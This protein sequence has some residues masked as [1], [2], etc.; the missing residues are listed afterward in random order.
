LIFLDDDGGELEYKDIVSFKVLFGYKINNSTLPFNKIIYVDAVNG[1][2]DTGDGTENNPYASPTVAKDNVTQDKTAIY[3]VNTGTY[4]I[5]QGLQ[6]LLLT[7]KSVDY[8][9]KKDHIGDVVFDLQ[10]TSFDKYIKMDEINRF[11]GIILTRSTG[12]DARVYEY[13]FNGSDPKIEFHNCVFSDEGSIIPGGFPIFTGNSGGNPLDKHFKYYNCTF[14]PD[15]D[16]KDDSSYNNIYGD[17]VNSAH[18]TADF[19]TDDYNLNN[20]SFDAEYNITSGNW[21]DVGTGEDPDGSQADIGV[22]GGPY[23]WGEW[24]EEP[25]NEIE[26]SVSFLAQALAMIE[27]KRL[28]TGR[29]NMIG[30]SILSSETQRLKS[31]RF[32]ITGNSAI[33]SEVKILKGGRFNIAASGKM[34]SEGMAIRNA[35]SSIIVQGKLDVYALKLFIPSGVYQI[36]KDDYFRKNQPNA[37]VANYIIVET[38]PLKPTDA[39]E[40]VYRSV[41]TIDIGAGVT[42]T[43]TV[44]YQKKPVIDAIA[45]L[46]DNAVDTSID[47]VTYYSWGASVKVTNSGAGADVYTIVVDGKPLEVRGAEKVVAYDDQSIV[48]NGRI[49]Y[50]LPKNH[51]IQTKAMAQAIADMLLA[52]FKNPYR[53]IEIE[54]RGNPALVLADIMNVPEYGEEYGNFYITSQS[55]RYDGGLVVTTKGKKVE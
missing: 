34:T 30:N 41:E 36:T 16:Y 42:Q 21:E 12:G 33:S 49:K 11:I 7:D 45:S 20:A 48:E 25:G 5:A 26:A 23:A 15:F 38:Q 4:S 50:T 31:G 32:S 14:L 2:D 3:I 24:E 46:E 29:A 44:F 19:T 35:E 43:T 55:M 40:E 28:R 1:D 54:W 13:F 53:D 10:T 22:Y 51:L 8:V 9:V 39:A 6:R 37:E 18:T 27:G 47:S 52:S 17:F